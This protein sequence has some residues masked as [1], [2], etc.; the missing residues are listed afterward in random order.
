M[1]SLPKMIV[2]CD[3]GHDDAIALVVAAH[4]AELVGVTTVAGNA[5]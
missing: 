1:T 4:F 2:D 3:P 5:P